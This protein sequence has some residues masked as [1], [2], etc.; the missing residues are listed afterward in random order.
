MESFAQ[1][2]DVV[3]EFC[4]EQESETIYNIWLKGI[5]P[6]SFEGG[7]ATVSVSSDFIK[8]MVEERYLD[9]IKRGFRQVMGFDVEVKITSRT[10]VPEVS[11]AP[12]RASSEDYTFDNFIVGP[13]NRFAHA[14]AIAVAANPAKAYNPLFIYGSS[15]LGKT[16]LLRAIQND[17]KANRPELKVLYLGCEQFTN[18]LI[19]AIQSGSTEPFHEKYRSVDVL[20]VDDV[21]FLGGKDSTQEEF[22]HTFNALHSAQKQI[23]LTSD[24]PAKEIKSLEERLRTRFEWGIIADVQPP[25]VETRISIIFTKAEALGLKLPADVADFIANNVKN[26]IRQLEGAVKKLAAYNQMDGVAPSIGLAQNAIKDIMSEQTP[27]PVT[28]EKIISEVGRTYSV[29][30]E[31]IRSTKQTA[32]VSLPRQVAMYIVHEVTGLTMVKIGAEFGG[33]NHATVVYGISKVEKLIDADTHLH[34]LIDDIVKN[35]KN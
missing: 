23:V 19:A 6:V 9:L 2:L 24:R 4:K 18:E 29:S 26:D 35:V 1:C 3:K 10:A 27:I 7:V 5:E 20:L 11:T 16:H 15:G 32:N 25:D 21:Q 31:D 14:A 34:E 33:R 12:L 22:F 8:T 30:P 17:L 28:V 13:D